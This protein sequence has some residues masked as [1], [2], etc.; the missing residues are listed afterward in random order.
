MKTEERTQEQKNIWKAEN[1]KIFSVKEV[2][3]LHHIWIEQEEN[4]K[5]FY[6]IMLNDGLRKIKD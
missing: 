3:E 6:E 2:I 4:P 5:S 1:F